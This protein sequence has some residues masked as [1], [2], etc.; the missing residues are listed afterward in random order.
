MEFWELCEM[1]ANVNDTTTT[2]TAK[3]GVGNPIIL[4]KGYSVQNDSMKEMMDRFFVRVDIHYSRKVY[5]SGVLF[6]GILSLI[7]LP[8]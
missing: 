6:I 2:P 5:F 4:Q 1:E 7:R 3:M 8:T